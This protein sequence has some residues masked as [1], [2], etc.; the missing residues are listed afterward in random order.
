MKFA[1]F[2][3]LDCSIAKTL[4]V[5]GDKWTLMILREC[6][7]RVRRF[8]VFE[9]RLGISR[10][11]LSVRL[12]SLVSNGVLVRVA[13]GAAGRRFE[14]RLTQK[15]LDLYPI[16]L[17]LMSWGDKWES[18]DGPPLVL[19]HQLCGQVTSGVLVCTECKGPIDARDMRPEQQRSSTDY[20]QN[21]L[22][23]K[24]FAE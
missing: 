5:I 19:R 23:P 7:M 2:E 9:Q 1:D 15:G 17:S 6:F 10:H 21:A 13:Y 3:Q 8:D 11:L 18:S 24:R 4:S 22:K 12:K 20:D 16:F 14:Y